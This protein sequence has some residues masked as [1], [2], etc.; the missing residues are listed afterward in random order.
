MNLSQ[1][2]A[3]QGG[4]VLPRQGVRLRAALSEEDQRCGVGRGGGHHH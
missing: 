3:M 1:G 2:W 4:P